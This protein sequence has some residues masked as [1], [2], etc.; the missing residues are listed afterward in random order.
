MGL[1]TELSLYPVGDDVAVFAATGNWG[2]GSR[3]IVSHS[4]LSDETYIARSHGSASCSN[5][6]YP[7]VSF[8]ACI[9]LVQHDRVGFLLWYEYLEL[10]FRVP[11]SVAKQ[12]WA[13]TFRCFRH[14]S[15]FPGTVSILAT[16]ASLPI[17]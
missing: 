13:C 16:I 8:R 9:D 4:V 17:C 2:V 10:Y 7:R 5:C 15:R 12:R 1:C 3:F 14:S 6:A 11:G